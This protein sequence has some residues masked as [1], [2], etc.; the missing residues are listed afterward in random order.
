MRRTVT[1]KERSHLLPFNASEPYW[2]FMVDYEYQG[3]LHSFRTAGDDH[4]PPD[5][6][7]NEEA[8]PPRCAGQ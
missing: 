5:E 4:G 8:P 7:S 2:D 1:E 3:R 6:V